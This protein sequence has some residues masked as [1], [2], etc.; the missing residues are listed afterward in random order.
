MRVGMK[1]IP[2][3]N[4]RLVESESRDIYIDILINQSSLFHRDSVL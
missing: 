1:Y 3:N 2:F 4:N